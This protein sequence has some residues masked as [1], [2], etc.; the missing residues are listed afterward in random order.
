[1]SKERV[2]GYE[3]FTSEDAENALS[4]LQSED[5]PKNIEE[6]EAAISGKSRAEKLEQI[7]AED[8]IT[9]EKETRLKERKE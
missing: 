1:M 8:K 7:E 3:S 6:L 4:G 9:A 2:E 5:L